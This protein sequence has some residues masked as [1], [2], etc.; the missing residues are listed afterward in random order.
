MEAPTVVV[1]PFRYF[2]EAEVHGSQLVQ[3]Q[4]G[5]G[6][7]YQNNQGYV[8]RLYLKEQQTKKNHSNCL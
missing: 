5:P 2:L 3:G 6:N 8:G 1:S 7:D 4:P